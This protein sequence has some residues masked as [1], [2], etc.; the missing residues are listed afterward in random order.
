MDI[1][2]DATGLPASPRPSL[3]GPGEEDRLDDLRRR[4]A[5]GSGGAIR[6]LGNRGSG[7]SA[8]LDQVIDQAATFRVLRVRAVAA[9]QE[10]PFAALHLLCGELLDHYAFLSAT[11]LATLQAAFGLIDEPRPAVGAVASAVLELL[12]GIAEAQPVCAAVDDAHWL[13]EPSAE[14]LAFVAAQA[15]GRALMIIIAGSR[16]PRLDPFGQVPAMRLRPIGHGELRGQPRAVLPGLVDD[17][18]AERMLAESGGNLCELVESL[19]GHPAAEL[20]GG[21]G[22]PGPRRVRACSNEGYCSS[23][24]GHLTPVSRRLLLAAAADPT[25]DVLLFERMTAELGADGETLVA[26]H[27]VVVG[28][29]VTFACPDLRSVSYHSA[30]PAERRLIHRKLAENTAGDPTRRLW[31][32]GLAA[33][34]HDDALA[35]DLETHADLAQPRGG[36]AAPAVA[37]LER[38]ALLTSDPTGRADRA[39]AASAAMYDYG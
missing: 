8:A 34:A 16:P 32:L 15:T 24:I 23:A 21:F 36:A 1:D 33:A 7:S 19:R 25:G 2:P 3:F 26:A 12:S 10:I 31:H 11:H 27:L 30:A 28:D 5:A 14:V 4:T 22:I 17:A 29:H 38:A 35:D 39:L 6:I 37:F 20:A 9:E 13:D 18:V